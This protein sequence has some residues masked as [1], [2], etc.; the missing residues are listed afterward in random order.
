[1]SEIP[2]AFGNSTPTARRAQDPVTSHYREL[3]GLM[4]DA[5]Y[6]RIPVIGD[7]DFYHV[8]RLATRMGAV[9]EAAYNGP[10][11]I[12][13]IPHVLP[14]INIATWKDEEVLGV[15]RDTLRRFGLT[16]AGW[17]YLLALPTDRSWMLSNVPGGRE[18][19][20]IGGL[21][22]RT[23][24]LAEIAIWPKQHEVAELVLSR[25]LLEHEMPAAI[26]ETLLVV[27]RRM[28]EHAD[29]FAKRSGQYREFM[30][31]AIGVL[32][33]VD[34]E[35]PVLE[36]NQ[37]A[38]SWATISHRSHLWHEEER[39]RALREE[40]ERR[41]VLAEMRQRDAERALRVQ[42]EW[43]ASHRWGTLID[44]FFTADG[45]EVLPLLS[46]DLL[47]EESC[48]M[49][50]CVRTYAGRCMRR[51]S[52]IFS[53]RRNDESLATVEFVATASGPWTL[54]QIRGPDNADVSP[55]LSAIAGRLLKDWEKAR[56]ENAPEIFPEWLT[57]APAET[58]KT[59]E[60]PS[61]P[62]QEAADVAIVP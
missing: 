45:Y 37:R 20:S 10:S 41:R 1:M 30:T 53:I 35:R 51:E 17:R 16:K 47:E 32:D 4:R 21:V 6:P 25:H 58:E 54:M 50:H 34:R 31:Q 40:E 27:C 39:V 22:R 62:P 28:W 48:R 52:R 12:P 15:V 7:R 3:V 56:L 49:G 60:R 8:A 19:H 23:Q 36:R 33:W 38:S 24:A 46:A 57:R 9:R 2:G 11:L 5:G 13:L 29:T 59:A 26:R 55:A 42:E 14:H 43:N 61:E 18:G 44:R